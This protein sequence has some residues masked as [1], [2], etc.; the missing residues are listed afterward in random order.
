MAAIHY[1]GT[2]GGFRRYAI[3]ALRRA[4][5]RG[6]EIQTHSRRIQIELFRARLLDAGLF[7]GDPR[8]VA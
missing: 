4:A 5:M 1:R 8:G 2:A 7:L 6:W 3:P